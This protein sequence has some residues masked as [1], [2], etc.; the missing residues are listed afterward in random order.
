MAIHR[1]ARPA[2]LP[3]CRRRRQHRWQA[4]QRSRQANVQAP[5]ACRAPAAPVC[6]LER[7][8][9]ARAPRGGGGGAAGVQAAAG[10][11]GAHLAAQLAAQGKGGEGAVVHA[12]LVQ[13]AD[14]QLHRAVVLGGDQLVGPRAAGGGEMCVCL[15]GGAG[16]GHVWAG[17]GV[18]LWQERP[19][20]PRAAKPAVLPIL[21]RLAAAAPATGGVSCCW[22]LG[23]SSPAPVA[24][25]LHVLLMLPRAAH[26]RLLCAAEGM[27]GLCKRSWSGS[28][29]WLP[30]AT[31][32]GAT[33]QQLQAPSASRPHAPLARD[34]QIDN[35]ALQH[36]E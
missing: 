32:A 29:C 7:G 36:R 4:G 31:S 27:R 22:R 6:L 24:G 18:L 23:T 12:A 17:S 8:L 34:V 35:L 14:V 26:A 11:S 21:A 20:L 9:D 1:L 30:L 2:W 15:W 5:L 10:A 25:G 13:V 28:C 19:G 3:P 16:R 33:A